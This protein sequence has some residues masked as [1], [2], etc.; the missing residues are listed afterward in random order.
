[1]ALNFAIDAVV[2]TTQPSSLR[3]EPVEASVH[4]GLDGSY[5]AYTPQKGRILRVTWGVD[6]ATLAVLAELR[7]KRGSTPLHTLTWNNEAGSGQSMSA[8]WPGNPQYEQLPSELIR[9]FT[10]VFYEA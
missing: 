2:M 9:S 10:I 1:M 7:S 6:V 8:I 3:D 5:T 4:R